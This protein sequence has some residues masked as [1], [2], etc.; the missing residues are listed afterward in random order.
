MSP[1]RS[2]RKPRTD[3]SAPAPEKDVPELLEQVFGPLPRGQ[4]LYSEPPDDPVFERFAA[5]VAGD[6]LNGAG[7]TL[8]QQVQAAAG[9]YPML[10]ITT[11]HLFP[12]DTSPA[13]PRRRRRRALSRSPGRREFYWRRS[14]Q[15]HCI[16]HY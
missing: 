15:P 12:R 13:S 4:I 5:T 11:E 1:R 2:P 16:V 3:R 8:D 7:L 9:L 10:L 6:T 14:R